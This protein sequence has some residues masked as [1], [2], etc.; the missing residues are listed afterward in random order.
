MI[1]IIEKIISEYHS[2]FKG[3]F[4]EDRLDCVLIDIYS[5][6]DCTFDNKIEIW[7]K[8]SNLLKNNV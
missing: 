5:E 7:N 6:Y 8:V 3:D 1:D 2:R 4:N